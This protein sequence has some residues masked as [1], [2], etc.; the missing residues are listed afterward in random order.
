[1]GY[2]SLDMIVKIWALNLGENAIMYK[3]FRTYIYG[4]FINKLLNFVS[5]E[6]HARFIWY[7]LHTCH[8]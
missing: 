8:N 3:R 5:I 1:M 7:F 2:N 4:L 6:Y